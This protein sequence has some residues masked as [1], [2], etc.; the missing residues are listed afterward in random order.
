MPPSSGQLRSCH[1][2]GLIQ[3]LPSL[4]QGEYAVCARCASRLGHGDPRRNRWS[5]I[6]AVSA[7][8]L[9]LPAMLLPLLRIERLGHMQQDSLLSGVVTL[10][11]DGHWLVGAVVCLFSVLLPPLKLVALLVLSTGRAVSRHR[12]RALVYRLVER[13]GRWGM[14]DVMLVALLVAMVKLGDL[15]NIQPGQGLTAFIALVLLSLLAGLA[16]NPQLMWQEGPEQSL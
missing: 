2:C 13:L 6:L 14:L 12:Q 16:F 4:G 11:S 8:A 15:V 10:W 1:C 5:A 7:L 9:Y 3:R